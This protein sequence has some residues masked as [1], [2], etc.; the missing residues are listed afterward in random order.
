[1]RISEFEQRLADEEKML[2]K[3][4]TEMETALSKM[5]NQLLWLLNITG[6]YNS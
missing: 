2:K 6:N 1:V 5:K 3:Q 4:F